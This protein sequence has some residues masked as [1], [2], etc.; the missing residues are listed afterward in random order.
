MARPLHNLTRK[1]VPFDCDKNYKAAF[2]ELKDWLTSTPILVAP[3]DEGQYILD[4]DMSDTGLGPCSN[5]N[6]TVSCT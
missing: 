1:N 5:R 2:L 3:C 4:T 6:R